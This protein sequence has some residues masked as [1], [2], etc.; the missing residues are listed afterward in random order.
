MLRFKLYRRVE[1]FD[2]NYSEDGVFGLIDFTVKL[3]DMVFLKEPGSSQESKKLFDAVLLYENDIDVEHAYLSLVEYDDYD[4][5]S[6][7][8]DTREFIGFRNM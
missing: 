2:L 6:E 8:S 4:V 7:D 1:K 5:L 3:T